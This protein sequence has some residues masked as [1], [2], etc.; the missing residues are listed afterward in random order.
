MQTDLIKSNEVLKDSRFTVDQIELLKQTVCKNA[1]NDEFK[2]FC[3]A[4]HRSGLDPFMKQIHAVKRWNAKLGRDEMTVQVGIDGYRLIADRTGLYAGNDEAIFDREPKPTKATVTVYKI[5]QGQRCAFTATARWSEYYPGDK[6]GFM[7]NKMPC[8]ML[9]KVAETLALRKAFP[10][11]LSGLYTQEEMDQ[12]D[13][14]VLNENGHVLPRGGIVPEAGN[15]DGATPKGEVI[16][17]PKVQIVAKVN[18]PQ[19]HKPEP[20]KETGMFDDFQGQLITEDLESYIPASG[21][22]KGIP[23]RQKSDEELKLYFKDTMLAIA[24]SG[25]PFEQHSLERQEILNT[26]EKVLKGR[27]VF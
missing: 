2:L 21:R 7:W 25:K 17:V 23:L 24:Q 11:E 1:T 27:K 13:K 6:Q 3:Y 9:G 5:V 20:K 8:V 12:A 14:E 15:Q 26:I 19:E 18:P 16:N 10:A 4:V 22:L